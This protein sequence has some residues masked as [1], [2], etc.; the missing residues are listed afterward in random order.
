M[1]L[2]LVIE[3]IAALNTL[4]RDVFIE[5]IKHMM[6]ILTL[7]ITAVLGSAMTSHAYSILGGKETSVT[8]EYTLECKDGRQLQFIRVDGL[9]YYDDATFEDIDDVK[10]ARYCE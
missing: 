9:W 6:K 4:V 5:R 3:L 10:A 1:S 8:L 7:A 2:I